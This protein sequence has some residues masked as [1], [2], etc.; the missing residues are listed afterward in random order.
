MNAPTVQDGL[1][2][3]VAFYKD[4]RCEV[5]ARTSYEAQ[6][7]AARLFKAR[8][9]HDVTVVLCERGDGSQVTH[10]PQGVTP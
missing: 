3:Y 10:T 9:A 1:C 5:L 8:K 4:R 7:Q 6:Q 2:G